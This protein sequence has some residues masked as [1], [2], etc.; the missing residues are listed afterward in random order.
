MWGLSSHDTKHH[1]TILDKDKIGKLMRDIRAYR[2][3]QLTHVALRI[4]PYI[5]QRPGMIRQMRWEHVQ[6]ENGLWTV[7]A[8][9]MKMGEEH[10]VPLPRQVVE[11]LLDLQ[12]LTGPSGKRMTG[13][14]TSIFLEV[15]GAAHYF[16]AY[17][18]NLDIMTS[19]AKATAER[20]AARM[21]AMTVY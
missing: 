3:N 4:L 5:W 18:G 21:L 15:E 14:K 1:A 2:G 9:M 13:L 8:N 12:P 11:L 7:P 20:M 6:L 19:A 17:A 16:P 10:E